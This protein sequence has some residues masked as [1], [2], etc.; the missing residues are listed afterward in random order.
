M[1][2]TKKRKC[3]KRIK[4]LEEIWDYAHCIECEKSFTEMALLE[5]E[6]ELKLS[7]SGHIQTR[8]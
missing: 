3:R 1:K 5:K 7:K 2:N 4:S 8:I 6:R